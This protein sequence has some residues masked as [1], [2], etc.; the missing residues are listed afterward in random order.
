M[1]YLILVQETLA[2]WNVVALLEIGS[3]A[4]EEAVP[5]S[6][7]DTRV[8]I[9]GADRCVINLL[10]EPE[11]PQAFKEFVV[12]REGCRPLVLEWDAFNEPVSNRVSEALG[13]PI[14]LAV[15]DTSYASFLLDRVGDYPSDEHSFLFQN[16]VL[17]DPDRFIANRR[18]ALDGLV[19]PDLVHYYRDRVRWRLERMAVYAKPH[20]ADGVKLAESGQIL[21]GA[22]AVR[23]LRDAVAARSYAE[24]GRFVYRK[25]DV[26]CFVAERYPQH[27]AIV[28]EVYSWKTDSEVR[29]QMV[30]EFREA[31]TSLYAQFKAAT[32]ALH[33]AVEEILER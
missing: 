9:E 6:D 15:V 1:Q 22:H 11:P 14:T 26:L 7:I 3:F 19:I 23:C 28:A 17:Y 18:A 24:T 29:A 12:Q 5:T 20:P 8:Y 4:K 32:L 27:T 10:H 21:W 33:R 16:N 30:R 13:V 2:Q 31:P 25:R